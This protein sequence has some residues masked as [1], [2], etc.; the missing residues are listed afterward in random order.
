[1]KQLLLLSAAIIALGACGPSPDDLAERFQQHKAAYEKV[2]E[3]AAAQ[4]PET[5][6]SYGYKESYFYL[7]GNSHEH[8]PPEVNMIARNSK[9]DR[10]IFVHGSYTSRGES[11]EV[12]IM[13]QDNSGAITYKYSEL[14]PMTFALELGNSSERL[15]EEWNLSQIE[16]NW[17][18]YEHVLREKK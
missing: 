4:K 11:R 5:V 14:E 12:G 9:Q 2:I 8:D 13:Y 16:G 18:T 10:I 1:M 17:Y 3:A 7:F 15:E 6:V